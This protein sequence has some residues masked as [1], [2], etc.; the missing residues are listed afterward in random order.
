MLIKPCSASQALVS[1][2]VCLEFGLTYM[3]CEGPKF[4]VVSQGGD[5]WM[6]QFVVWNL[7]CLPLGVFTATEIGTWLRR[8][9]TPTDEQ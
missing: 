8:Y 6:T 2:L 1:P 3:L 7:A 4:G 5:P 9:N